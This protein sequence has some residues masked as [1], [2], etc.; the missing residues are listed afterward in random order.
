M[1]Q[2]KLLTFKNQP[3]NVELRTCDRNGKQLF[4]LKQEKLWSFEKAWKVLIAKI[5]TLIVKNISPLNF[6]KYQSC[7]EVQK[8]D[9][10]NNCNR[11][12]QAG[13]LF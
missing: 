4:Q 2:S 3:I 13:S 9:V 6:A 1:S 7:S 8:K 11:F 5:D 12:Q 10:G